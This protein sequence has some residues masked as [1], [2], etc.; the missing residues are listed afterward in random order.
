VR[1]PAGPEPSSETTPTRQP[2]RQAAKRAQFP[3]DRERLLDLFSDLDKENA[4][5]DGMQPH[6]IEEPV[7][8]KYKNRWKR[9]AP[10]TRQWIWT[11]YLEYRKTNPLP[12]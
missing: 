6:E 8:A 5:R 9:L 4:F 1:V 3:T 7:V 11:V 2:R 10:P 12:R